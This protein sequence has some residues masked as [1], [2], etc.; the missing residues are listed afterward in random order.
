ME[1]AKGKSQPLKYYGFSRLSFMIILTTLV[2]YSLT[3]PDNIVSPS[4]GQSGNFLLYLHA[5][6]GEAARTG[7]ELMERVPCDV[8]EYKILAAA[9]QIVDFGLKD[10]GYEYFNS[11]H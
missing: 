5:S 10:V 7:M 6:V 3:L 11:T 9:N 4:L 1:G 8:S 2:V